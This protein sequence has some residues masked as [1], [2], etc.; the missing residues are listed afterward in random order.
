MSKI[1]PESKVLTSGD[2]AA[3][4]LGSTDGAEA[5]ERRAKAVPMLVW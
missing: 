1:V 3:L 5:N 4:L 2:V